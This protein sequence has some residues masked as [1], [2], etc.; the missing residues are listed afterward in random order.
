M[1]AFGCVLAL[2]ILYFSKRWPRKVLLLFGL[3]VIGLGVSLL[4]N[5]LDPAHLSLN[6]NGGLGYRYAAAA[7]GNSSE[8]VFQRTSF[9][10]GLWQLR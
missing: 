5:L 8:A 10:R 7:M 1:V 4:G 9:W 3:V 2:A 6:A